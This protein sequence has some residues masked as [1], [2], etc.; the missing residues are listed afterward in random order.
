MSEKQIP[1]CSKV[2]GAI[3]VNSVT[4]NILRI[5]VEVNLKSIFYKI[6]SISEIGSCWSICKGQEKEKIFP[7]S[8]I[9]ILLYYT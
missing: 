6:P 7:N 4:V 8:F 1:I 5:M 3:I 9:S 2:K